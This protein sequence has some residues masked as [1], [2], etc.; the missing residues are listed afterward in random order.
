M[1]LRT[2]RAPPVAA[3]KGEEPSPR[4]RVGPWVPVTPL[5]GPWQPGG[6]SMVR[7]ALPSLDRREIP[8][9][10]HPEGLLQL[11]FGGKSNAVIHLAACPG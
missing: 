10:R 6:D 4:Q 3:E 7:R 1:R 11:L 9:R 2:P 5:L 8:E